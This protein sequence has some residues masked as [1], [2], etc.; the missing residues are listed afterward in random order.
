MTGIF[1]PTRRGLLT[2]AAAAG[3]ALVTLPWLGGQQ[4]WAQGA[5]LTIALPNNPVTIDPINQLNHDAMVLGQT[6]FENLVEF[7]IDGTLKPQLAKALPQISA[8]MLTYSFELRDDVVFHDGQKLTAEDVKYSFE[9]MLNPDNKASRRSIF[10][11]L[12]RVEVDSPTKLRVILKEPYA[13]WLFFLTKYMGIFPKG[14]REK[15]GQD[16]FKSSPTGVGTGPGMFEEW[17]PNDYIAFKRNPNWWRKDLPHWERLVVR[18]IPEDSVRVAYLLTGQTDIISAPPPRDFPRLQKMP[19]VTGGSRPTNGGWF[20]M[21]ANNAKAPFDDVNFR[22]AIAHA[23]D[24]KRLAEKVYFGLL[25]A[26]AIPAPPHGWW[27]DKQADDSLAFDL[28]KAKEYLA[29]SKYANGAEFDML[30][31]ATPYL[32]DV[33]DAAL[34]LQADLAKINVKINLKMQEFN[35][36]LQQTI[37]GEHQSTLFVFMQPGEP[38]YLIMA[39]YSGGQVLT[40]SSNYTHPEVDQ[41]LKDAFAETDQEKLK[42]IYAKM[43]R[44]LADDS[45][46]IWF[47][48]VHAANLWRQGVTGFKPSAGLT[49]NV[50]ET[51]PG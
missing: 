38:T 41:A 34:V 12:D 25:D 4:A 51:K 30:L 44:R 43:L 28:D 19:N 33:K 17:R 6:V 9:H 5:T 15:Y 32:L 39:T 27:Y 29:K 36:V 3:G 40:K 45:P 20:V 22:K 11:R 42:G 31:P 26:C 18:I 8:D 37:K 13:P 7:D 16:H 23:V 21:C 35:V 10:T 50:H 47:G 46:H 1:Q 49:M 48:F 14:S 24:R 2:G